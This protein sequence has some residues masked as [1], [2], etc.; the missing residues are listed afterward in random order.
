LLLCLPAAGYGQEIYHQ[1]G[2]E[3]DATASVV[4][5]L[6]RLKN[7]YV[8]PRPGEIDSSVS[9]GDML[10]PGDD[11]ERWSDTVGAE[12]VGYVVDVKKGG[13]ETCN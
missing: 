7:R 1:C 10:E 8:P 4:R 12:V 3:G 6:N 2:M 9:L 5:Q 13:M 11:E